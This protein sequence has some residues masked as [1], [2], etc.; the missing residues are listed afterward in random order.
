MRPMAPKAGSWIFLHSPTLAREYGKI[1][2]YFIGPQFRLVI[3]NDFEVAKQMANDENFSHR[4]AHF[5]VKHMRGNGR[6]TGVIATSG[7]AWRRNRRFSLTTLKEFGLGKSVME[8]AIQ[9]EALEAIE[10]MKQDVGVGQDVLIDQNF[11]IPIFNIIWRIATN[12]RYSVSFFD[13]LG[14]L[15]DFKIH[16]IQHDDPFISNQIKDLSQ[17]FINAPTIAFMPWARC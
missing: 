10:R 12:N 13:I 16:S 17:V 9:E 3:V 5:V 6:E 11:N 1:M 14:S 2:G 15:Y 7:E 4:P 8:T